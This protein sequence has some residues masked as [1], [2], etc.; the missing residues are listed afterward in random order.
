MEQYEFAVQF[1]KIECVHKSG[2]DSPHDEVYLKVLTYADPNNPQAY[3]PTTYFEGSPLGMNASNDSMRFVDLTVKA[4]GLTKIVLE[5]FEKDSGTDDYLGSMEV[6]RANALVTGEDVVTDIYQTLG[7][8]KGHYKVYWRVVNK[9]LPSLRILGIMCQKGSSG[10]D[11]DQIK[12]VAAIKSEVAGAASD[13]IGLVPTP[14]A[15]LI[16]DAF[17]VAAVTVKMKAAIEVWLKN[18]IEGNDDV[19]LQ[20]VAADQGDDAGGAFW[21]SSGSNVKMND[22][23]QFAFLE[24]QTHYYRFPMD[25]GPVTIQVRERDGVLGGRDV[26]LGAMTI[27]AADYTALK[28]KGAQVMVLTDFLHDRNNGEGAIY[29]LCY[30]L[31]QEDWAKDATPSAQGYATT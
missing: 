9:P 23:V 22:N 24:T 27:S 15:Q 16:S 10:C 3:N 21:P 4:T 31:G 30:S 2:E 1:N 18:A 5:L 13:V 7:E 12:R 26:S 8:K 29:H 19:Y 20:R 11:A 25:Q 14:R 6:T 28:D 17:A